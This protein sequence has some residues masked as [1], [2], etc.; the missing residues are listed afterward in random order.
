MIPADVANSLRP[1]LTD[2][3]GLGNRPLQTQPTA[4]TQ[5]IIDVLGDL[6]P[7]QRLFAEIQAL[8]PN[9]SYRAVIGQRDIT[10]A[11]PFSAKSGDSLELEVVDTDGNVAL[12]VVGKR[13]GGETGAAGQESVPTTL[14]RTGRLIGD[15]L[16]DIDTQGK[17]AAPAP[18]NG[19]QA[20]VES[21]ANSGAE[22]APILKQALT[23]SGMFYEAHQ[24]RWASGQ[25]PTTD[26]LQEPQGKLS[27]LQPPPSSQGAATRSPEAPTSNASNQAPTPAQAEAGKKTDSMLSTV[28]VS[29]NTSGTTDQTSNASGT[30]AVH[31]SLT[32][33]VQQQLD[34]LA[35]QNF[36]WQGQIWPGQQMSWE[37][38]E[39]AGNEDKQANE[40]GIHW[41]TRLKLDL[42]G[43]GEI[44]ATLSLRGGQQLEVSMTARDTASEQRLTTEAGSLSAQLEGAGLTLTRFSVQHDQVE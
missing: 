23:Q 30:V 34:A 38:E 15:I 16:G 39:N 18:L 25:L 32:P 8:L 29:A 42:P 26:L 33:L 36:V 44:E 24:A 11:L 14:S 37:I 31:P 22:L 5:R 19:N 3:Q 9:G 41:K 2:P 7:G 10:L 6:V 20:L 35:T 17:R 12:A 28:N 4:P 21:M 1:L 43:L 13:P 27:T 40:S